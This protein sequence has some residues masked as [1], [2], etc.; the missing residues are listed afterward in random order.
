MAC[1]ILK[2]DIAS[3]LDLIANQQ[4]RDV[5]RK[6]VGRIGRS[7]DFSSNADSWKSKRQ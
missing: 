4:S 5:F 2:R 3:Y 1:K 6:R 7:G